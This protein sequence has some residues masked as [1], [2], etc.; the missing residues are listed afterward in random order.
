MLIAS[1]AEKELG[2]A[3][4]I[5]GSSWVKQVNSDLMFLLISELSAW[6][7]LDEGSILA[8]RRETGARIIFR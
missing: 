2:R 1:G 8:T 3:K 6:V 4:K 7:T 5:M